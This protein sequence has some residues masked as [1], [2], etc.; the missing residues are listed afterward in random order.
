MRC[1]GPI[2]TRLSKLRMRLNVDACGS[3]HLELEHLGNCPDGNCW[4][5]RVENTDTEEVSIATKSKSASR[6]SAEDS[7]ETGH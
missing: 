4:R 6:L 7:N 3:G 2:Q 1:L 5:G